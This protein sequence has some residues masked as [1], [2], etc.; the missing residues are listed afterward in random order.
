MGGRG[1]AAGVIKGGAVS[2]NV[3]SLGEAKQGRINTTG[4][5][6]SRTTNSPASDAQIKAIESAFR[7]KV[8]N[9]QEKQEALR[10]A[11]KKARASTEMNASYSGI[12][13]TKAQL[14]KGTF[15][16]LD[17]T[18]VKEIK[19]MPTG[20]ELFKNIKSNLRDLNKAKKSKYA[21]EIISLLR[22]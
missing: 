7:T 17:T 10:S 1:S 2:R 20:R 15:Q 12:K 22:K 19:G 21:N 18:I 5:I 4:L 13:L 11:M 9:I 16:R 3:M 14:R 8:E 6:M